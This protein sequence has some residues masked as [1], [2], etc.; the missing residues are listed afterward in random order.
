[1]TS[2]YLE[3]RDCVEK[4]RVLI[5]EDYSIVHQGFSIMIHRYSD[6][7]DIGEA[8]DGAVTIKMPG[9]SMDW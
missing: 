3:P 2:H 5:A 9:S 4:F 6:I 1:M 7:E 8:S